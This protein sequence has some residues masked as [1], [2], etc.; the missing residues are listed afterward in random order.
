MDNLQKFKKQCKLYAGGCGGLGILIAIMAGITEAKYESALR[1]SIKYPLLHP[2]P[3]PVDT[4]MLIT[5]AS[6]CLIGVI[7]AVAALVAANL[8][9]AYRKDVTQ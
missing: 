3:E 9:I 7:I 1:D 2:E 5:F 6:I 8:L 4:S